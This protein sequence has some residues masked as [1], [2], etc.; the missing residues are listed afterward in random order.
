LLPGPWSMPPT[1]SRPALARAFPVR[2]HQTLQPP[3]TPPETINRH[4][5]FTP[6][7]HERTRAVRACLY[8]AADAGAIGLGWVGPFSPSAALSSC[9]PPLPPSTALSAVL[10]TQHQPLVALTLEVPCVTP[11]LPLLLSNLTTRYSPLS[12]SL[13]R[14]RH[15][16]GAEKTRFQLGGAREAMRETG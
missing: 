8:G 15:C 9:P 10:S 5:G 4:T 11:S 1:R 12:R 14:Q 13:T 2:S 16:H 3:A 7:P 6:L